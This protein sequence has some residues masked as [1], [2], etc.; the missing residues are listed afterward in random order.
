MNGMVQCC[1][2]MREGKRLQPAR[3]LGRHY[4]RLATVELTGAARVQDCKLVQKWSHE[5]VNT[6]PADE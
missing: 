4:H 5:A 2:L 1:V 3:R 6:C